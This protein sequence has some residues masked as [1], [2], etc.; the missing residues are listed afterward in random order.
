MLTCSSEQVRSS[1]CILSR[2][3]LCRR[4]SLSRPRG[5]A[6]SRMLLSCSRGSE[7]YR[8]GWRTSGHSYPLLQCPG[9]SADNAMSSSL[10][11]CLGWLIISHLRVGPAVV[12]DVVDMIRECSLLSQVPGPLELLRAGRPGDPVG[13][14]VVPPHTS[15]LLTKDK[16]VKVS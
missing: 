13:V 4:P 11:T 1:S 9:S 3:E 7:G 8:G 12:D 15:L 16:N 5:S 14:S 10:R 6:A 2:E